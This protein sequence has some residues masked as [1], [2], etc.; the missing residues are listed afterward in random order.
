MT[1][2]VY[3][4]QASRSVSS[5]RNHRN[6]SN[7][8]NEQL[9]LFGFELTKGDIVIDVTVNELI[10][11]FMFF[12]QGPVSENEFITLKAKREEIQSQ[13]EALL[14]NLRSTEQR[15]EFLSAIYHPRINIIEVIQHKAIRG[16]NLPKG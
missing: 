10:M 12:G 13:V 15:F 11:Y 5:W 9:A 3:H 4:G 8:F 16:I 1:A 2:Q 6:P 7:Q 14:N